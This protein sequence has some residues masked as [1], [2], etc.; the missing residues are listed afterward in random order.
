MQKE[1]D[2]NM[3]VVNDV[4]EFHNVSIKELN[5]AM[6]SGFD[7][8]TVTGP[9][10]DEPMQGAVFILESISLDKAAAEEQQIK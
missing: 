6:I 7:L 9:L 5:S 2:Q 10:M 8:A 3:K 1:Y 4:V